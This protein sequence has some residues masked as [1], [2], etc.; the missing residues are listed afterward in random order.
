M[1]WEWHSKTFTNSANIV[2]WIHWME[3]EFE[4]GVTDLS[5]TP[6]MTKGGLM[7]LVIIKVEFGG[8]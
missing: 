2:S 3:L 6:Y 1:F 4:G 8:E 7:W 5:V